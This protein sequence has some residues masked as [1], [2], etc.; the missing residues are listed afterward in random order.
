MK[1]VKLVS[2]PKY[3]ELS[4]K[5]LYP[6]VEVD[7]ELM[8]YFP[9][10]QKKSQFPDREYFL[11]VLNT[12]RNELTQNII[13]KAQSLRNTAADQQKQDQYIYMSSDWQAKLEAIPFVSSKCTNPNISCRAARQHHSSAEAEVTADEAESSEEEVLYRHLSAASQSRI[14]EAARARRR[15][16]N[17]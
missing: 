5:A 9:T 11:N 14:S 12:L 17:R 6:Q 8:L 3:E 15:H 10:K 16:G 1:D 7:T 13:A 2:V 4:V